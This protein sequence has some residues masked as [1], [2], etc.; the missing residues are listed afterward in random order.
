MW[1]DLPEA[2]GLGS[3]GSYPTMVRSSGLSGC[4]VGPIHNRTSSKSVVGYRSEVSSVHKLSGKGFRQSHR[5]PV[6]VQN[7]NLS[8]P[9]SDLVYQRPLAHRTIP[10]ERLSSDSSCQIRVGRRSHCQHS[11]LQNDQYA[12][13]FGKV[14]SASL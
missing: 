1:S 8:D 11:I 13:L 14:F 10:S 12:I 5:A 2:R 6:S 4:D 7:S 3:C 9:A